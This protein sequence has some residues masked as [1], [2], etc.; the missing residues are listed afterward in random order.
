MPGRERRLF[1]SDL[2]TAAAMRGREDIFAWAIN[3]GMKC[4]RMCASARRPPA[5]PTW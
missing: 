2:L 3:A 5:K 1:D 4:A